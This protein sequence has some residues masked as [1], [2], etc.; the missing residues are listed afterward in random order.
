MARDLQLSCLFL[1][2]QELAVHPPVIFKLEYHL[3][4]AFVS[5]S[6]IPRYLV[7]LFFFVETRSNGSRALVLVLT[8][9]VPSC[10]T[11]S[12]TMSW[13]MALPAALLASGF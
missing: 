8:L 1:V 11:V 13:R 5:S 3:P 2:F 6:L 9:T 4:C 10:C 12:I 7:F